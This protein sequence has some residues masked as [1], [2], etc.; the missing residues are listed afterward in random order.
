MSPPHRRSRSRVHPSPATAH[1]SGELRRKIRFG[2]KHRITLT[3]V[4]AHRIR[5]VT[6]AVNNL[7]GRLALLQLC[8][9]LAPGHAFGHDHVREHQIDLPIELI[10]NPK[11]FDPRARLQDAVLVFLKDFANQFPQNR[12]VLN[13]QDRLFS[14]PHG[15]GRRRRLVCRR[16]VRNRGQEDFKRGANAKLAVNLD[17]ALMLL[18]NA[19]HCSQPASS[20]LAALRG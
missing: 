20:A 8:G 3:K 15:F 1:R 9:Q 18:N 7:E 2:Q 16:G 11:R 14:A 19:V 5:A 17:P 10:P 12:L 13:H 6:A 4:P